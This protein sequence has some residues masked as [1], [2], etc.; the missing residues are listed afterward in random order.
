MDVRSGQDS[1]T[2]SDPLA[3]TG[4][5]LLLTTI[6]SP[7]S[8]TCGRAPLIRC[9]VIAPDLNNG[10]EPVFFEALEAAVAAGTHPEIA[11]DN[12]DLGSCLLQLG[13]CL[14]AVARTQTGERRRREQQRIRRRQQPS[15]NPDERLDNSVVW[16]HR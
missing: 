4:T 13:G 8:S 6:G 12:T 9:G 3:T 7:C 1:G 16:F 5:A 14:N 15:S 10:P 2:C 11:T